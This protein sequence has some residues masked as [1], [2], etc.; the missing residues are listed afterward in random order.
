MS[1]LFTEFFQHSRDTSGAKRAS[2]A[3]MIASVVVLSSVALMGYQTWMD[4]HH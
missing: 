4:K 3:A 2:R 1:P